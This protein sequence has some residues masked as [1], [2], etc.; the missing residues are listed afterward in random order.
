VFKENIIIE[1]VVSFDDF[2]NIF[3]PELNKKLIGKSKIRNKP[4]RLSI[5]ELMTVQI[6]FHLK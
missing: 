4:C 5:S 3:E 2:S 1:I 6:A